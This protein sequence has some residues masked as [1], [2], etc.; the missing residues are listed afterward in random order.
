MRREQQTNRG[1]VFMVAIWTCD[2]C[3]Q[4]LP[5]GEKAAVAHLSYS[6]GGDP[7]EKPIDLCRACAAE[8]SG[9]IRQWWRARYDVQQQDLRRGVALT[10]QPAKGLETSRG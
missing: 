3:R 2:R 10:G 4:R 8:L 1:V 5:E 6:S 9:V 7:A